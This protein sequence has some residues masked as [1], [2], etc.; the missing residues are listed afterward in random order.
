M[1]G[2]RNHPN[3][4][5]SKE[6][7]LKL[8]NL[9][10]I[11]NQSINSVAKENKIDKSQLRRWIEKYYEF[12]EKGLINK[13]KPGNPLMKYSSRKELNELEKLEYENM[14]LKIENERLKK[15]YMMKGDGTVVV[16]K[17]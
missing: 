7:K 3:R 9:V 6:D 4:Y 15:G 16:Y 12:G 5:W 13:R 14:K 2:K 17:K 8:V 10:I 11:N 1:A